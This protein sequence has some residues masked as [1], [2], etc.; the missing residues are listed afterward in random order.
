MGIYPM[1]RITA[2]NRESS[3]WRLTGSWWKVP[4]RSPLMWGAG[5]VLLQGQC[6]VSPARHP[7]ALLRQH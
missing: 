2:V 6:S 1:H 7:M 5:D 4:P 3:G